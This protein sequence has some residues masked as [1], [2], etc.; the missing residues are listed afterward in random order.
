V[1]EA[2]ASE[3]A[4]TQLL[5]MLA[6]TSNQ[7]VPVESEPLVHDVAFTPDAMIA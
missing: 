6:V 3:G 1:R 2:V 7:Y 5:P 4:L